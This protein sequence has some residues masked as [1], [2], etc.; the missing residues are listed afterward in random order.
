MSD[1]KFESYLDGYDSPDEAS[2]E[3]INEA[4]NDMG[5]ACD[6]SSCEYEESMLF[7]V[8]SAARALIAIAIELKG[9]A[10]NRE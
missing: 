10:A 4:L 9:L 8:E 2:A 6:Q 3:S 1:S 7:A 5:W